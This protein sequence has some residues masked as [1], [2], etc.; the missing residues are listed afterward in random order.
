VDRVEDI[1][2]IVQVEYVAPVDELPYRNEG[3]TKRDMEVG[4]GLARWA[5]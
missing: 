3:K 4:F 5:K 2:P 1:R